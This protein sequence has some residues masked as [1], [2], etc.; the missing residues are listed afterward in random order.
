MLPK[1]DVVKIMENLSVRQSK[2]PFRGLVAR[3]DLFVILA[4]LIFLVLNALK[5][6]LFNFYIIPVQTA[7]TFKYKFVITV[8]FIVALYPFILIIKSRALFIILYI[9]QSVYI[10]AYIAYYLYFRS[11]LNLLQ[12][13]TLY[14]E[15]SGAAGHFAVPKSAKLLIVLMDLPLFVYLVFNYYH[16]VRLNLKLRYQRIAVMVLS[17]LIILSIESQNYI[18]GYSLVQYASDKYRGESPIVQRYGT[19]ANNIVSLYEN[20][21]DKELVNNLSYGKQQSSKTE[22]K[23]NPNFVIIQVES[24]DANV[25]NQKY[26][27]EY[28][29]PF[30]HSLSGQ[31]VYYPYVLSYHMG[32]GTSDSEFSIINSVEPLENYPVI[33]LANYDYPNSM[34]KALSKGSYSA[35]AFHGNVG[36]F[37]NRDVAFPK[38]GFSKFIDKSKMNLKD[39]GWGAPDSQVFNYVENYLK[40]VK[41]PFV[42]YTI[43][44]TSHGPFTNA[45]NYYN[46]HLYDDIKDETVRNYFNS[47]SYVDQSIKDYVAYI[48]SNFPN[49]YVFIWGDHT[50]GINTDLYKQAS[51]TTDDK[52]FEFVPLLIVTP[53][54]KVYKE[55]Q[56]VA[57]FLDISPTILSASGVDFNI[58]SNGLNLIN[59][60]EAPGTIPFKSGSYDRTLL[61]NRIKAE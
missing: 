21:G 17:L 33:K 36:D 54:K 53:D 19:L 15:A 18:N 48:E 3:K 59:P 12:W 5:V 57:S 30:L 1:G 25:I 58:K 42:S 4:V 52:Y 40:N 14:K 41:Q 46:N 56:K 27:G 45:S 29:A 6:T 11:Y 43:T 13:I 24:M 47:M 32:G 34:V 20:K 10:V 44:M 16:V 23:S 39:V 9:V 60:D 7:D 28:I 51:L 8:L 22:V 2:T 61:F 37:F 49:T 50:P 55:E 38:M 31:S 26:K 35:V